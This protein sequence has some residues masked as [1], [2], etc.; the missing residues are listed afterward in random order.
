MGFIESEKAA[1]GYEVGKS[2]SY[3]AYGVSPDRWTQEEYMAHW[4][5]I[6]DRAKRSASGSYAR[7]VGETLAAPANYLESHIA[8]NLAR[9]LDDLDIWHPAWDDPHHREFMWHNV[10]MLGSAAYAPIAIAKAIFQN[11]KLVALGPEG[12]GQIGIEAQKIWS[13]G[14]ATFGRRHPEATDQIVKMFGADPLMWVGPMVDMAK[15]PG[16]ARD[17][18]GMTQA[19]RDAREATTP[20]A[21]VLAITR[22]E[23]AEP[24]PAVLKAI[25]D[26]GNTPEQAAVALRSH[27]MNFVEPGKEFDRGYRLPFFRRS[28]ELVAPELR[29]LVKK[30]PAVKDAA[31]LQHKQAIEAW[32]DA[33]LHLDPEDIKDIQRIL[34]NVHT[35]P[36]MSPRD[37]G[38]FI[39]RE[40]AQAIAAGEWAPHLQ[41]GPDGTV[42]R[43]P[44]Q[45]SYPG[46]P[47]PDN[48][49]Q[50]DLAMTH[51]P[52]A[53]AIEAAAIYR[54]LTKGGHVAEAPFMTNY[55][56]GFK[57]PG[58]GMRGGG[59]R[60]GEPGW[61][62][63]R[64][65]GVDLAADF[66]DLQKWAYG[67]FLREDVL[68][69]PH[70]ETLDLNWQGKPEWA[71]K[72]LNR[73]L[74]EA[75]SA[76]TG[77]PK[78]DIHDAP[79]VTMFQAEIKERLAR[80]SGLRY[81]AKM[82][83]EQNQVERYSRAMIETKALAAAVLDIAKKNPDVMEDASKMEQV[84]RQA[85]AYVRMGQTTIN[86]GWL[87]SKHLDGM[88]RNLLTTG[89]VNG[90][91]KA[92]FLTG[93]APV[94]GIDGELMDFTHDNSHFQSM[95]VPETG[96]KQVL[97]SVSKRVDGYHQQIH[98]GLKYAEKVRFYTQQ[99]L[100]PE[101]IHGLAKADALE[102][103]RRVFPDYSD[104]SKFLDTMAPY[105]MYLKH[106]ILYNAMPI[107]KWA[108]GHPSE[109]VFAQR[110]LAL[111]YSQLAANRFGD[112]RVPGTEVGI[113]PE[114]P[115][116]ARRIAR[117]TADPLAV[118][119][120]A[121]SVAAKA[122]KFAQVF[123]GEPIP[124]IHYAA[125][126][127]G[128]EPEN[129]PDAHIPAMQVIDAVSRYLTGDSALGAVKHLAGSTADEQPDVFRDQQIKSYMAGQELMKAPVT[130]EQ[131]RDTVD[132]HNVVD[133]GLGYASGVR[134]K[135]ITPGM[136]ELHTLQDRFKEHVDADG[137]VAGQKMLDEVPE[138]RGTF[139]PN[140]DVNEK[141]YSAM[142][143]F[144]DAEEFQRQAPKLL[145]SPIPIQDQMLK[146]AP[147]GVYEKLLDLWNRGVD[148][149]KKEAVFQGGD[150]EAHA[151]DLPGA[152]LVK[153][154]NTYTTADESLDAHGYA[155]GSVD[156]EVKRISGLKTDTRTKLA[157]Q[158]IDRSPSNAEVIRKVEQYD[159]T[160]GDHALSN[161][162]KDDEHQK[163]YYISR[164][165]NVLRD[166]DSR[167]G[168]LSV[169]NAQKQINAAVREWVGAGGPDAK[170]RQTMS[171]ADVQQ[172]VANKGLTAENYALNAWDAPA[173]R[174]ALQ[175]AAPAVDSA[176]IKYQEH[177]RQNFP[178]NASAESMLD[179][180][181]RQQA[182]RPGSDPRIVS[183]AT[184]KINDAI[185]TGYF[186]NEKISPD[187]WKVLAGPAGS[188]SQNELFNTAAV[189][190][191]AP[192]MDAQLA[193]LFTT[194]P[195]TGR[196]NGL[197][198]DNMTQILGL[199]GGKLSLAFAE[200]HGTPDQAKA[201][202]NFAAG[203]DKTVEKGLVP[204][205]G[206]YHD[207][208]P[209]G[210]DAIWQMT[211]PD[212]AVKTGVMNHWSNTLGEGLPANPDTTKSGIDAAAAAL[213][214][215]SKK[216][217]DSALADT[218]G[219][220]SGSGQALESQP[221][222][223]G[224]EGA[225]GGA[226]PG[227]PSQPAQEAMASAVAFNRENGTKVNNIG[228]LLGEGGLSFPL[229]DSSAKAARTADRPY[230]SVLGFLRD[231]L[232]KHV[233][234]VETWNKGGRIGA[235]PSLVSQG[236]AGMTYQAPMLDERGQQI[237]TTDSSGNSV[238]ATST[239]VA[240]PIEQTLGAIDSLG[241]VAGQLSAFGAQGSPNAAAAGNVF[242]S[243]GMGMT[244]YGALGHLGLAATIPTGFGAVAAGSAATPAA[245]LIAADFGGTAAAAPLAAAPAAGVLASEGV[246]TGAAA[247]ATATSADAAVLSSMG[248][249]AAT[250]GST[251]WGLP[252]AAVVAVAAAAYAFST[253]AFGKHDSSAQERADM[254]H[255]RLLAQQAQFAENER[256]TSISGVEQREHALATGGAG[257]TAAQRAQVQPQLAAF[258]RRPT[259]QSR[260]G[261][262][263]SAER[264]IGSA[265]HPKW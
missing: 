60:I 6:L 259:Y 86:P 173:I 239:A 21:R 190:Y 177:L 20:G 231:T 111:Q 193:N 214:P 120:E 261:L 65:A 147:T 217:M 124:P 197:S 206:K 79:A 46:T 179:A 28:S 246:V 265:I 125:R 167:E 98:G 100:P 7:F 11:P 8:G 87:H 80:L 264:A 18:A 4:G 135:L 101:S 127:A 52:S 51:E 138:I 256:K 26:K 25:L 249:T 13:Q 29:D 45:W 76:M 202:Q 253:G 171:V 201:I 220:H 152:Q 176:R 113:N 47:N 83:G 134:L 22:L 42:T 170:M 3:D 262:A 67:T 252:V 227:G 164:I 241:K 41:P 5:R 211:A 37:S 255:S 233:S 72:Y 160:F 34:H 234:A 10:P 23:G 260:I 81:A 188:K 96:W 36:E 174:Q 92:A 216:L 242:Q 144:H 223:L 222:A 66:H 12:F 9:T 75:L 85:L 55:S 185:A 105:F 203:W 49:A 62:K 35:G 19:I 155:S 133:A 199:P 77:L 93:H 115:F 117:L 240:I 143:K 186:G 137:R 69:V 108:A 175:L 236:F 17:L 57:A 247:D 204:G 157:L 118:I 31:W 104:S 131:A 225:V 194:D 95:D 263:D 71:Q 221:Q 213:A 74:D 228:Q 132:A 244:V 189:F 172:L 198:L 70:G 73:R 59:P 50:A 33:A 254:A 209:I 237:M 219:G 38:N 181:V 139:N 88:A 128:L 61:W 159:T 165:G 82:A 187:F 44:R 43:V 191:H 16:L 162:I 97:D 195:K 1:G 200:A 78:P 126:L 192:E 14:H 146:A 140:T 207:M 161:W 27:G 205:A 149:V 56:K 136:A 184:D 54:E 63:E 245:G 158:D 107:L 122:F 182:S 248:T 168:P 258:Q 154:G 148:A 94:R 48:P 166:P 53:G 212:Y 251:G 123:T 106:H 163:E 103:V 215:T 119:P 2:G 250:A 15:A 112:V 238:G 32:K 145:E 153:K 141:A 116:T 24:T 156:D 64:V 102:S 229:T 84:L 218:A 68:G 130:Y 89:E 180:T 232:D 150:G 178:G 114:D 196:V 183:E 243:V 121:D 91:Y 30:W 230:T 39:R 226:T 90:D 235:E 169:Y 224:P 99:G 208:V 210:V 142:D 257:M 40:M 58:G 151:E 129:S 110:G 109:A